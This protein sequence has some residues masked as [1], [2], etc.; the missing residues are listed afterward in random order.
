MLIQALEL[1]RQ[2]LNTFIAASIPLTNPEPVVL[3]NIAFSTPDNPAT[4]TLDESAQI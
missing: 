4:Q 1:I 2:N 3:G